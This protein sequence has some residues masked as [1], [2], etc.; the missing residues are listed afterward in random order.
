MLEQ[1]F[2]MKKFIK[3]ALILLSAFDLSCNREPTFP[4][5]GRGAIQISGHILHGYLVTCISFDSRGTAWIGTFKQGLIRYDGQA[6]VYHSDNTALP[7]SAVMWD[8]TVDKNDVVWIGTD[9]GLIRFDREDFTLFTASNSPLAENA[10]WSLAVGQ[11]NA[12]WLASCR[13]KSGGL[14]KYDGVHWTLFTP[15]NSELPFHGVRD[16]I[17]DRSN[18]LWAAVNG[19]V[20]DGRIIKI[21]GDHWTIFDEKD[22]GF[23]PYNFGALAGDAGSDWYASMDYSLSDSSVMTR[24]NLLRYDGQNWTV[25][26][27]VDGEGEPAGEVGR[28]AVDFFGNVW[29]VLHGREGFNLGVFDGRTWIFNDSPIPAGWGSDIAVDPTSGV[30]LGTGD[31]VYQAEL[32]LKTG[33]SPERIQ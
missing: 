24:P 28:I 12:L 15:D 11:D 19:G 3:F 14:M 18:N 13:F 21:T 6:T 10:V 1:S 23:A 27:P 17:V 4:G 2:D 7:D 9:R 29:A 26:N 20:G 22:F 32:G 25:I 16:V 31:G 30:W 33:R 5:F 8:I